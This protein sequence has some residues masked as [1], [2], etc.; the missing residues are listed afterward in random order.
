MVFQQS[1]ADHCSLTVSAWLSS[2]HPSLLWFLY[3]TKT[4]IEMKMTFGTND[5]LIL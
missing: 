1:Q 2:A 4:T 3:K 5:H